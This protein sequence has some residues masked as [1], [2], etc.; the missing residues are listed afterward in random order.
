MLDNAADLSIL[1]VAN[2]RG[3][4]HMKRLS[5]TQTVVLITILALLFTLAAAVYSYTGPD[6]TV[7]TQVAACVWEKS[8]CEFVASKGDYRWHVV[9]SV[10]CAS[11]S[12]PWLDG[13]NYP[14]ECF[15]PGGHTR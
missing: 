7:A 11:E 1:L 14:G 12:K 6:R 9:D 5:S 13:E 3:G 15:A 8:S 2:E 4:M 10:S